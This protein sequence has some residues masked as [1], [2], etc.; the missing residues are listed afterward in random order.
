VAQRFITRRFN[1]RAF[2]IV[3]LAGPHGQILSPTRITISRD[4]LRPTS[5]LT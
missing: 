2:R 4:I 5:R 3:V 1:R